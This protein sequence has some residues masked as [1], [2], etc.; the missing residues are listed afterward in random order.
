MCDSEGCRGAA[1]QER[2]SQTTMAAP[3]TPLD[4]PRASMYDPVGVRAP[5]LATH[6]GGA[7]VHGAVGLHP[8]VVG[9]GRMGDG[10]PGRKRWMRST[11]SENR[12][13]GARCSNIDLAAE[14]LG[15]PPRRPGGGN[16]RV[17]G[18]RGGKAGGV[19]ARGGP[20]RWCSALHSRTTRQVTLRKGLTGQHRS[21]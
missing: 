1:V 8:T 3:R 17:K 5:S 15:R 7:R 4:S 11:G 6:G 10:G 21:W 18:I 19:S 20:M 16:P 2:S 9:S 14:T 13:G 12:M